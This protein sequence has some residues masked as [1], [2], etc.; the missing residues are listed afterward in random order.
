MGVAEYLRR[1][2]EYPELERTNKGHRIAGVE[3]DFKRSLCPT[4]G[5][6]C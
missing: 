3:R 1:V 4:E 5:L 6:D 2:I